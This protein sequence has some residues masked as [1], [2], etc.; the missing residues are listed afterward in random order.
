[1]TCVCRQKPNRD[2]QKHILQRK[3]KLSAFCAD[4][5]AQTS[6]YSIRFARITKQTIANVIS[7]SI[8]QSFSQSVKQPMFLF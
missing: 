4:A 6:A 5:S 1:M 7:P 8:I 3:P 2:V